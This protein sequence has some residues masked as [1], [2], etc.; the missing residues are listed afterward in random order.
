MV[1][2]F[3][4]PGPAPV[5]YERGIDVSNSREPSPVSNTLGTRLP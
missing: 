4:S 3:V 2:G 5:R 1:I